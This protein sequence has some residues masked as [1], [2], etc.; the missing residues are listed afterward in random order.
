MFMILFLLLKI[1]ENSK[2][3]RRKTNNFLLLFTC[4]FQCQHDSKQKELETVRGMMSSV[5]SSLLL[6][7]KYQKQKDDIFCNDLNRS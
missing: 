2:D 3:P 6:T 1:L 4:E 5:A 7:E